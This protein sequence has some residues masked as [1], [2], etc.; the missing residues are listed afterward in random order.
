MD[1][2]QL[3]SLALI[4]IS[5]EVPTCMELKDDTG[6][7]LKL[8]AIM[9]DRFTQRLKYCHVH[10]ITQYVAHFFVAFVRVICVEFK[11]HRK[12]THKRLNSLKSAWTSRHS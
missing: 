12:N 9:A 10:L 8:G 4:K 5:S 2:I 1:I 3:M 11:G 6:E 7:D